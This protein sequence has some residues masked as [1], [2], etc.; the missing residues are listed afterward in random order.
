MAIFP[1]SPVPDTPYGVQD[2][3]RTLA[4]PEY[5]SG[6]V[7]FKSLRNYSLLSAN[8]I[9]GQ[10]TLWSD[11]SGASGLYDFFISVKGT[12]VAFTFID[13]NGWDNSPI[14]IRWPRLRSE[15]R[16]VGKEC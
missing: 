8:L 12:A 4:S 5:D 13:F 11:I 2:T 7:V 14:G 1:T 9:Y 6:L 10:H 15:E 16:R 3:F